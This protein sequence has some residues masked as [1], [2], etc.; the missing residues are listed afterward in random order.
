[1]KCR[2]CGVRKPRRWCPGVN[3][4]ICS[5]CCGTQREVTV[6]CPL[7]CVYLQEART[8]ER[9]ERL[10]EASLPNGDIVVRTDFVEAH[11]SQLAAISA[12][13]ARAAQLEPGAVD[14]DLLDALEALIRTWRT[15][16]TGLYY[17]SRP[18]NAVAARIFDRFQEGLQE[19][20]R[21][22]Q[23]DAA[24]FPSDSE[25]LVLL[26]FLQRV[27]LDRNNGRPLGRAFFELLLRQSGMD[28]QAAA[29]VS[30]LIHT[31]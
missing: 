31:A 24:P 15:L 6:R 9:A 26:A 23:K 8:H 17:D 29:P 2:I 27:A 30:P 25:V 5:I 1:L 14:S 3:G 16:S 12:V 4:D 21:E 22:M 11:I 18:A 28:E 7:S 10:D 20:R 19:L 13:L